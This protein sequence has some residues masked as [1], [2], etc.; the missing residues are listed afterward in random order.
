MRKLAVCF[1][2]QAVLFIASSAQADPPER[3]CVLKRS[4]VEIGIILVPPN[5]TV[6]DC[7]GVLKQLVKPASTRSWDLLC[8][9]Q[10]QVYFWT[11]LQ[12]IQFDPPALAPPDVSQRCSA[13]WSLPP[14]AH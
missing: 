10:T 3:L 12:W 5:W 9:I 8:K 7:T 2:L 13:V 6:D 4:G 11:G 14:P 1:V